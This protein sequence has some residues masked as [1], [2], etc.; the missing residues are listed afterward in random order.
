MW[1][2]S[3][4]DEAALHRDGGE[5]LSHGSHCFEFYH[6]NKLFFVP[7]DTETGSVQHV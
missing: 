3:G 1:R 2:T 6:T 7:P 5:S 4:V